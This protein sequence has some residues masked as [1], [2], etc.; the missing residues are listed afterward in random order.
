MLKKT[1]LAGIV[2]A[3]VCSAAQ[4]DLYISPIV[5]DSAQ[6]ETIESRKDNGQGARIQ[7]HS[8]AHGNFV[9][10]ENIGSGSTLR[11]GKDVPIFIAIESVIPDAKKWTV[12]YD[13]VQ[14]LA[15][16]WKGGETWQS[17]LDVIAD[18][19]DLEITVNETERAIGVSFDK[20]MSHA[21]ASTNP[22]IW[23]L[24]TE[25]TL[26][27]NLKAWAG[28]A[29][30]RLSWDETL[31]IDYPVFHSAVLTGDFE[32][33]SGVVSKILKSTKNSDTPLA[34]TFY[35]ANNV[36]RIHAAGFAK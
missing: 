7:G 19:N 8:K 12:H 1:I 11:F 30:W 4:A 2:A 36:L 22:K 26:R 27:E 25:R 32:G 31:Q 21:L 17:V 29:G 6:I 35:T 5:R 33:P 9:M 13:G 18:Q 24:S 3:T 15:V 20:R 34:G 16:S 14:D 23:E 10:R 28:K